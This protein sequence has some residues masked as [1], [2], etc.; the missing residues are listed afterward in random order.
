MAS[1]FLSQDNLEMSLS[2]D[3]SIS[4]VSVQFFNRNAMATICREIMNLMALIQRLSSN[5]RGS[6]PL[7]TTRK[8]W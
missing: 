8:L 6:W 5:L 1:L 3:P 4:Q 7:C 2:A